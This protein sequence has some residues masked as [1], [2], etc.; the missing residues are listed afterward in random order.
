MLAHLS[1]VLPDAE[2]L[3]AQFPDYFS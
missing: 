2:T 1:A 3:K